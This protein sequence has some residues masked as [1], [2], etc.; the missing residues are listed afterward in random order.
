NTTAQPLRAETPRAALEAAPA[1]QPAPVAAY[2]AP[3]PAPA[4]HEP[5]AARI[6]DAQP[7]LYAAPP[8]TAVQSPATMA[9]I[10]DPAVAEPEE[11]D[12]PLFADPAYET[13][14]PRGGFLSLFGGRPRYEPPPV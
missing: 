12:E 11:D 13:R 9:R 1:P 6:Q 2:E 3:A 14:R 8:A 10:V 5:A 7:D 4:A